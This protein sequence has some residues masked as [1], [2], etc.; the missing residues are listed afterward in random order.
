MVQLASSVHE[1]IASPHPQ[2]SKHVEAMARFAASKNINI[3]HGK[4]L[5]PKRIA[6]SFVC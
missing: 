2:P 6:S 1:S 3:T 5:L 4:T